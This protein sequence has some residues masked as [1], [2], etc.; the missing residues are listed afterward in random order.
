MAT[1]TYLPW[2]RE[3]LISAVTGPASDGRIELT[4]QADI[5]GGSGAT[6]Q[7]VRILLFGP[8]DVTGFDARQVIR[9]DPPALTTDFE[10]NYFPLVEFDRPDFPWLFTP[11]APDSK[12]RLKQPWICLIAVEKRDGVEL[13]YQEGQPLPVLTIEQDAHLELPDLAEAWAW[14]QAQVGSV[15]TE[16]DLRDALAGQPERTL[17]RLMCPRRLKSKTAYYA[18]IVPTYWGGVQAG[19]G[20]AVEVKK[21]L[22]PAWLQNPPSPVRLP[23]YYHWEFSTGGQGDFEALVWQL[24]RRRLT[25]HE[26]GTR[27]LDISQAGY[28]LPASD[29]V[30]LE[31]AL[32]PGATP[33]QEQAGPAADYQ[34]RLQALVNGTALPPVPVLPPPIYGRWHAAQRTIP[35]P[36]S[37]TR[38]RD[39][40]WLRAINLDPRYRVA[41]GLGAR[42]V[43]EQQEQLMASAWDQ[44][45][46]IERA[47]Q[48]L[49]QAQLA[50]A[51]SV[52]IYQERLGQLDAPAFLLVT[53]PVQPRVRYVAGQ[54]GQEL[55]ARG[56]VRASALPDAATSVQFRRAL[57]PRGPLARRFGIADA[58]RRNSLISRLN[59]SEIKPAPDSWPTPRHMLTMENL[60]GRSPCS[61][62]PERL[63]REMAERWP[64]ESLI[65]VIF[66]VLATFDGGRPEIGT[67][68]EGEILQL[69]QA[70][71]NLAKAREQLQI[72]IDQAGRIGPELKLVVSLYRPALA[73][74][75]EAEWIIARVARSRPPSQYR[76][77]A[78]LEEVMKALPAGD[79]L[80]RILFGL[81]AI[82]HQQSREPCDTSPKRQRP[83]DM[84]ELKVRV[85]E[86]IDPRKT[87]A[88][89]V[90]MLIQA[91]G[92]KAD[93]LDLILAAPDF[94]TPM[95][96][97]LAELSQEWLLPGLERVPPNTLSLLESNT[98]FIE[99][100]MVGLNH[101]M[102]RELLWRGFPTDQRGTYFR[103]FWDPSGRFPAPE[104]EEESRANVERSKDIPPLH[105]WCDEKLGDNFGRPRSSPPCPPAGRDAAAPIVLLV[106]GDL[107]R[108]YPRASIFM[109]RAEWKNGLR[110]PVD[111]TPASVAQQVLY[112]LFHGELPPD[113]TFLG[114]QIGADEAIGDEDPGKNLPGWFIVIQQQPTEPRY[115]LD[116]SEATSGSEKWTWRDLAWPHVMLT[117]EN[118][119]I[120]LGEG[121]AGLDFPGHA[122]KGPNGETWKWNSDSAQMTCITLQGPVR[123]A[124]HASDLL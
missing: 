21:A 116:E 95:Y 22:E 5:S 105:E 55:T 35:D 56:H 68:G 33:D 39:R 101:E 15:V 63:A 13:K 88:A 82:I 117:H 26:V 3:G 57:R 81:A 76:I 6:T 98:R 16:K 61:V 23:V 9:T 112:P 59:R 121:G 12:N 51:A 37:P 38:T 50:R 80:R 72:Y 102:S 67:F 41:A 28:G 58:A 106:R 84:E 1:Y 87:I 65:D 73:L 74:L 25:F 104:S 108:R 97:A 19:L 54:T 43:R 86:K 92:W 89:R 45:G 71:K 7:P 90:G 18:C 122:Q 110:N 94:P 60:L 14:A 93:E 24:E 120:R 111:V 70:E 48:I 113:I 46:D 40:P 44:V 8:G 115:G 79:E 30:D 118:G 77:M 42:V 124:V 69:E 75:A 107:L 119:Y 64:A 53:G 96:R 4:V 32:A 62:S 109:V 2:V 99:A 47:N 31:G 100:F 83:L 103:Q 27:R 34:E 123:V 17:S 66:K 52:S 114:F 20:E 91:P 85:L 36:I 49:R 78:E 10:P 29:P 11:A